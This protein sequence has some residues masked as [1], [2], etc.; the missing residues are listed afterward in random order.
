MVMKDKLKL[1]AEKKQKAVEGRRPNLK[2]FS[3]ITKGAIHSE[4]KFTIGRLAKETGETVHTI[5][6]WTKEGLLYVSSYSAGGYQLYDPLMVEKIKKI[7][8]LQRERRLTI[9]EIKK[10]LQK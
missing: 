9:I 6:Y 3:T 4:T 10:L 7:R 5:R 1:L 2:G 8:K